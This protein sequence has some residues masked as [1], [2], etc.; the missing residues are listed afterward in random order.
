MHD[1]SLQEPEM[2]RHVA[3]AT[4]GRARGKISSTL[5]N[6]HK[7]ESI[8]RISPVYQQTGDGII[9]GQVPVQKALSEAS[10]GI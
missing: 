6:T 10:V 2:P 7:L 8:L 3:S 1:L 9:T 5:L 4:E